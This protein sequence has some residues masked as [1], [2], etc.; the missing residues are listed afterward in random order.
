MPDAVRYKRYLGDGVYA[1]FDGLDVVL[2]TENGL[3][4]TNRIVLEDSVLEAFSNWIEYVKAAV[5]NAGR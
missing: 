3:E 5:L 1:D 2:T 4:E